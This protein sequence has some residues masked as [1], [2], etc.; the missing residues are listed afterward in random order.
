IGVVGV[1]DL[2]RAFG[3]GGLV[4]RLAAAAATTAADEGQAEG[5]DDRDP[6]T[7]AGAGHRDL[8]WEGSAHPGRGE[9]VDA[10]KTGVAGGSSTSSAGRPSPTASRT[11]AAARPPARA[12]RRAGGGG[13]G[14]GAGA[15]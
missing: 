14:G 7:D 11:S 13:G 12:A 5:G 9:P 2:D 10:R 1:P 3:L 4:G 15:G 8:L 6:E